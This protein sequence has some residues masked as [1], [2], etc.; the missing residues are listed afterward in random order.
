M[1]N[2]ITTVISKANEY[3][4]KTVR[5]LLLLMVFGTFANVVWRYVF[6]KYSIPLNESVIIMNSMVFMLGAAYALQ[7]NQH[8]RVDVFYAK[9]SDKQKA[10]ADLLGTIFFLLPMCGFLLYASWGYALSSWQ[11][12]ES[13][14]STGGLPG[15][16][17][18]KTII[19][20]T[21]L[22]MLLQGM[23]EIVANFKKIRG[24][25]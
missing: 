17:L 20:L 10:V 6:E 9:F 1:I 11:I 25:S 14:A 24:V 5:W 19:P 22:L 12:H 13:S 3:I 4:G 21:A 7:T 18:V 2:L 16:Y 8:V 15:L 23:V